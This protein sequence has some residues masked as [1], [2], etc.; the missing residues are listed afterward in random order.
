MVGHRGAGV[1]SQRKGGGR[2]ARKQTIGRGR[3][4]LLPI[5]LA[6]VLVGTMM[7]GTGAVSLN[8]QGR[9]ANIALTSGSSAGVFISY[10]PGELWGG[11]NPAEHCAACAA[12]SLIGEDSAQSIQTG[13]PVDPITGDFTTGQTLILVPAKEGTLAL[14]LTYDNQRAMVEA[15]HPATH[16]YSEPGPFGWGWQSSFN[17]SLYNSGTATVTVNQANGSQLDFRAIGTLAGQIKRDGCPVGDNGDWQRYTAQGSTMAYCAA[18]RVDAQV[19]KNL[20]GESY[21][22]TQGGGTVSLF[23]YY[24]E[25]AATGTLQDP[26]AI[27]QTE[28][29][30]PGTSFHSAACPSTVAGDCDIEVTTLASTQRSI[31]AEQAVTGEV[32]AVYDPMGREY[33]FGYTGDGNLT[34]ITNF[35]HDT[36]HY[37][38]ETTSGTSAV[39]REMTSLTDPNGNQELVQYSNGMVAW[40]QV[41]AL[42]TSYSYSDTNC[43]ST[44]GCLENRNTPL[45]PVYQK[46]TVHYPDGEIDTDNYQGGFMLGDCY[47]STTGGSCNSSYDDVW[48]FSQTGPTTTTPNKTTT[49]TVLMPMSS[50]HI[51]KI[52]FDPSGNVVSYSDPNGNTSHYMYNDNGYRTFD[53]L[54]WTAAPGVSVPTNATCTNAPAGST[55]YNYNALGEKLAMIDPLGNRTDFGYYTTGQLCWTAPPSVIGGIPCTNGGTYPSGAPSGSA[56]GMYSSDGQVSRSYTA[57]NTAT[58]ALTTTTYNADGQVT[59]TIPPDGAGHGTPGSNPYE[60]TTTYTS[61]GLAKT[62]TAPTSRTT[63]NTYDAD[64]HVLTETDPAG[65]TTNTYDGLGR[66]CWTYRGTSAKFLHITSI[67]QHIAQVPADNH[68]TD[69]GHRPQRPHHHLHLRQRPV[70]DRTHGRPRSDGGGHPIHPLQRDGP[71]LR[72]RAGR[73][74]LDVWERQRRHVLDIQRRRAAHQDDQPERLGDPLRLQQQRLPHPAD[75]DDLCLADDQLSLQRQRSTGQDDQPRHHKRCQ[76]RRHHRLQRRLGTVLD[77]PGHMV[78]DI[79]GVLRGGTGRNRGQR[80]HVQHSR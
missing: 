67:G 27:E 30:R 19:G 42:T 71:S 41:Q 16:P 60:T 4:G 12:Q 73:H 28:G 49:E 33:T 61:A 55:H 79:A 57:W 20:D 31:V 18:S 63:T 53:Q 50:S 24:G 17:V 48:S 32:L 38:Y 80:V 62:V 14:S 72:R 65:V 78:L 68:C 10:A 2:V 29:V 15:R 69:V 22:V 39:Q 66:L 6:A 74:G 45:T 46:T 54:C 70:P 75:V 59:V 13:Q 25:L 9:G 7:L 47:G 1:M 11:G 26:T 5:G 43:A 40:T 35:T 8:A 56:V 37:G 51:P 44:T 3:G 52:T 36:T 76:H 21:D 58:A 64:G 77:R 34:G 23:N